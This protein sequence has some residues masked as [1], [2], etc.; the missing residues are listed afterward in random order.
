MRLQADRCL[1]VESS[2]ALLLPTEDFTAMVNYGVIPRIG[3]VPGMRVSKGKPNT[4]D[5]SVR[6]S[7]SF[8]RELYQTLEQ[9]AHQKKVSLAWI[10]RDAA[11]QYVSGKWPLFEQERRGKQ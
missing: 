11:E 5:A 9:I 8:P 2:S 3:G 6:A 7:I 10:V 4:D 1:I